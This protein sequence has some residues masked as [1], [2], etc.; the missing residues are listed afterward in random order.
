MRTVLSSTREVAQ[1][2]AAQKQDEGKASNLFFEK[3]KL[4]SY[5]THFCVAR[6][7]AP[8]VVAM[9]SQSGSNR[10]SNS[11]ST[12][13][14]YAESETEHL[15]K[16]Y[17][18][19]PDGAVWKNRIFATSKVKDALEDAVLPR[20]RQPRRDASNAEAVRL[21]IQFNEYL[22]ALQAGSREYTSGG[23]TDPLPET[24]QGLREH[25]LVQHT[26]ERIER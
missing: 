18:W 11:T 3:D 8:G 25:F 14:Y 15:K 1:Y 22:A 2:W 20:I 6:H 21:A 10:R 7:I 24:V 12:H 26:I 5:G 16:V 17:C 9:T 4:Y 19:E 23:N 13:I